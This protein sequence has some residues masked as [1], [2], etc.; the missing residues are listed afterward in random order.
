M[1]FILYV[2]YK[3]NEIFAKH[4]FVYNNPKFSSP[5]M[6]PFSQS[7]NHGLVSCWVWA[8]CC[9]WTLQS[10]QSRRWSI[11]SVCGCPFR[12]AEHTLFPFALQPLQL[13]VQKWGWVWQKKLE[14]SWKTMWAD[15]DEVKKHAKRPSRK[16]IIRKVRTRIRP[17]A[18]GIGPAG[19]VLMAVSA[20]KWKIKPLRGAVSSSLPQR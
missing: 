2:F 1:F 5:K 15:A 11:S 20:W 16:L 7:H 12:A 19:A 14:K 8:L 9:D 18:T 17:E 4:L 10:R 3:D 6:L 13:C